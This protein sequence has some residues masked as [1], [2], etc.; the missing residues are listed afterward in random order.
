M[1][2]TNA[3]TPLYSHTKLANGN[4]P[5]KRLLERVTVWSGICRLSVESPS[6]SFASQNS[7]EW[8]RWNVD[9]RIALLAPRSASHLIAAQTKAFST[10]FNYRGL[11]TVWHGIHWIPSWT[12]T[13][14]AFRYHDMQTSTNVSASVLPSHSFVCFIGCAHFAKCAPIELIPF[15]NLLHKQNEIKLLIEYVGWIVWNSHCE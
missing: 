7:V 15:F 14:Y 13:E 11:H 12:F 3:V 6:G 2:W 4:R 8:S 5:N 9:R 10:R 1:L